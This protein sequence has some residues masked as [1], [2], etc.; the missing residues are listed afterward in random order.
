M[1]FA[2][3]PASIYPVAELVEYLN[4]GFED[5]FIP[6]HFTNAMFLNM[7]HKDGIDL[8]ASRVLLADDQSLRHCVDRAAQR[9]AHQPARGDGNCQRNQRQ[10][11]WLLVHEETD[12]GS[13]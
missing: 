10:R 9:S 5:Y 11:G 7:L 6:I 8:S 13:L 12:R 4:R 2:T 3:K 1:D